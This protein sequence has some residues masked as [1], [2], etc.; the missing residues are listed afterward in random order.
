MTKSPQQDGVEPGRLRPK[1]VWGRSARIA[2]GREGRATL[3]GQAQ[4]AGADGPTSPGDLSGQEAEGVRGR[5]ARDLST[6]LRGCRTNLR[7]PET[8]PQG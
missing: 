7:G 8:W 5:G 3:S 2:G 4:G 1:S 6:L